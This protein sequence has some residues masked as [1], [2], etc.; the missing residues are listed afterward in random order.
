MS[1]QTIADIIAA[2]ANRH[3]RSPDT[4]NRIAQLE[5]SLNPGAQNPNSSAGG[6]FQFIDSTWSQ[7]G[8][9]SK[10]DPVANTDAAARYLGDVSSHLSGVLGREPEGW[11]LYLGH[12]QGPGGA[13]KLL[14]NPNALAA[15][16]V[17]HDAIRLNGGDPAS[18]T[19]ADFAGIWRNKF[20]GTAAAPGG[21]GGSPGTVRPYSG[22]GAIADLFSAPAAPR[23]PGQLLSAGLLDFQKRQDTRAEEEEAEKQRLAALF[24]VV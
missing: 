1:G 3:G 19:A 10:Y 16:L 18:T 15:S 23:T 24:S 14:G 17:G 7:Y 13:A 4:M 11:E 6:L 22:P 8:Q 5:S 20:N 21:P 2:V 9:G 12:Q